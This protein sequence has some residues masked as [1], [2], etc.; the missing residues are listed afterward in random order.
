[1]LIIIWTNVVDSIPCFPE[2]PPHQKF[3][4]KTKQ[5]NNNN[6]IPFH[7]IKYF[8]YIYLW[9]A[10]TAWMLSMMRYLTFLAEIECFILWSGKKNLRNKRTNR[11]VTI[12]GTSLPVGIFCRCSQK[13]THRVDNLS[14]WHSP[15]ESAPAK[16]AEW[17]H[18]RV[19]QG[20]RPITN[21][22][23]SRHFQH[24]T[25]SVMALFIVCMDLS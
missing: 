10:F 16:K 18:S 14:C 24:F 2:W 20:W 17:L 25:T 6:L 4:K 3:V 22:F 23:T 12:K 5:K 13:N 11:V 15:R 8:N 21:G 9:M 19:I 7:L 1:M